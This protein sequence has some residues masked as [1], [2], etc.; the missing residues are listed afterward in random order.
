[1][2]AVSQD[3]KEQTQPGGTKTSNPQTVLNF[4]VEA[5]ELLIYPIGNSLRFYAIEYR[6]N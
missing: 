5:G 3:G 2:V 1:M 4:D 6:S